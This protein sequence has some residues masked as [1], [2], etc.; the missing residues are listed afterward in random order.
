MRWKCRSGGLITMK[1]GLRDIAVFSHEW[2]HHTDNIYGG[3]DGESTREIEPHAYAR[4]GT[5]PGC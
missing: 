4:M 3:I 1:Q 5:E 2:F